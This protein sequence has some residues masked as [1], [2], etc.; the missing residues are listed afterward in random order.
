MKTEPIR[1]GG[2]VIE[3]V[4]IRS[5]EEPD[6]VELNRF[7]NV[8]REES[9]P[10]EPPRPLELT[11]AG[12][13]NFPPNIATWD[14]WGRDGDGTLLATG[15]TGYRR[16]E[17]NQHLAWA[18]VEVHPDY[19]R[20]GIA[21]TMLHLI[22]DVVAAEGRTLLM[23][24][25]TERVPAG[26]A[27]VR[28]FGAEPGLAQHINRLLLADIDRD[29]VLRW[30]A[31][32]PGRAPGYSLIA[33]DGPYPEELLEQILAAHNVMNTAP[34]DDL[35][36]EDESFTAEEARHWE[37][38]QEA[39]GDER[40]SLFARH[41]ATGEI[42]G[43]TEVT[44]NPKLPKSIWQ[45]GTAVRP[46]HRGHALGKWLKAAM[47]ERILAERSECEDIKTGNADSND[48]ML[49]INRQLGFK[50]HEASRLWQVSLERVR[51]YLDE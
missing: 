14:F 32:G 28:R 8:L 46:D 13:R 31:Q 41:D 25:T 6:I 43:F 22:A 23:L 9:H 45:M 30:V 26:E 7:G 17:E 27:F 12:I 49:A 39:R 44:W 47:I 24:G 37:R 50:P 10:E 3:E 29:L 34:R 48:P 5:I 15:G 38:S 16:G 1:V 51:A 36:F 42:I 33:I 35:Q 2:L 20:R 19:R 21:K 40:W 11:R 18:E 4:D